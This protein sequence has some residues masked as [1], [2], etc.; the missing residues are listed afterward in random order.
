VRDE[1]SG[2]RKRPTCVVVAL[3]GDSGTPTNFIKGGTVSS[4]QSGLKVSTEGGGRSRAR[5]SGVRRSGVEKKPKLRRG[6]PA[7]SQAVGSV[8]LGHVERGKLGPR[9]WHEACRGGSARPGASGR[10]CGR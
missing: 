1:P 10:G 2:G 6:V 5:W 8:R 3:T 4:A 7:A 9:Q